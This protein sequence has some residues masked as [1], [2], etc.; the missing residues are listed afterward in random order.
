MARFRAV[1]IRGARGS[2]LAG[3]VALRPARSGD[4]VRIFEIRAGVRENRLDDPGRVTEADCLWYVA[5][6][7]MHV[8]VD[9][10]AILGF[11][12]AD[13][14]DGTIWALFVDPAHEGRGIGRRLLER[15]CLDLRAAGFTEARLTTDPGTRAERFYVA[16]GWSPGDLMPNGERAFSR[17]LDIGETG[18]P[19]G[20]GRSRAGISRDRP[21]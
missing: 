15:A 7:L 5:R 18:G 3:E 21:S 1:P 16:R 17:R 6:A 14:R 20:P 2:P 12:A 4:L 11:S 8:A 10:A 13:T 19:T 9:E